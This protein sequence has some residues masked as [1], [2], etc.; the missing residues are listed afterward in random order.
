MEEVGGLEEILDVS[1]KM[2]VYVLY[3]SHCLEVDLVEDHS[4]L[5]VDGVEVCVLQM[6]VPYQ[7]YQDG[8]ITFLELEVYLTYPGLSICHLDADLHCLM[9]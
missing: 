8:L 9:S 7:D 5:L 6:V 4:H 1:L 2:L 3:E